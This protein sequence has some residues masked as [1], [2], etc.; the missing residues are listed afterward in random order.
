MRRRQDAP[1]DNPCP[2]LPMPLVSAA[3]IRSSA[4]SA[5]GPRQQFGHPGTLPHIPPVDPPMLPTPDAPAIL[6]LA[7]SRLQASAATNRTRSRF[8]QGHDI[9]VRI[10]QPS[11]HPLSL[12]PCPISSTST[13]TRPASPAL[14]RL[15]SARIFKID[16][17]SHRARVV[18]KQTTGAPRIIRLEYAIPRFLSA[19]VDERHG[20]IR[21]EYHHYYSPTKTLRRTSAR[22]DLHAAATSRTQLVHVNVEDA[23]ACPSVRKQE[24][25]FAAVA[26]VG[27]KFEEARS[28]RRERE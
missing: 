5:L 3:R 20:A 25:W 21:A 1:D 19:V 9:P 4:A 24:A 13:P 6:R 17:G 14:T 2:T 26:G 16:L 23:C 8:T 18:P 15:N 10:Y 7:H 27:A 12:L 22:P 11:F 28:G